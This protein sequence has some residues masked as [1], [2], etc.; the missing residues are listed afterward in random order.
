MWGITLGV[1]GKLLVI[2]AV[3]HMH[4]SIVKE[5]RIDRLVILSYKQERIITFVGLL[6]LVAGYF[7]EM[8]YY[9]PTL[10]LF[11]TN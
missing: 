1:V 9:N 5:H 6:L 7:L 4:H 10:F 3:L 2:L 8:A 11:L